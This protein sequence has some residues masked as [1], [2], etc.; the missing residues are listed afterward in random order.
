MKAL[1]SPAKSPKPK[2]SEVAKGK[3]G[4]QNALK[5]HKAGR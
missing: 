1:F 4:F 3:G 5:A 2:K